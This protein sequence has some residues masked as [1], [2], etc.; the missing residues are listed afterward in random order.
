VSV[1]QWRDVAERHAVQ[2]RALAEAMRST[3][4]LHGVGPV[5]LREILP[6]PLIGVDATALMIECALLTSSADRQRVGDAAGLARLA[7]L[8]ADGIVAWERSE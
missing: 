8:L 1:L 6:V 5:R 3:L 4:E 2:S 7:A